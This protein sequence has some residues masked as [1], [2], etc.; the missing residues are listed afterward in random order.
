[1]ST[2]EEVA[3]AICECLDEDL[4]VRSGSVLHDNLRAALAEASA[5]VALESVELQ[6]DTSGMCTVL[7]NGRVAIRDNGDVISH[8]ATLDWFSGTADKLLSEEC[9]DGDA[10]LRM[11]GLDPEQCR[12]E[13]GRLNLAKIRAALAEAEA[14]KAEPVAWMHNQRVDC[15]HNEVKELLKR[16]GGH[17]HRPLDKTENYTIPLY[18]HPPEPVDEEVIGKHSGASDKREWW[19]RSTWLYPGDTVVVR[20]AAA[21]GEGMNLDE[22]ERAL[23]P[24]DKTLSVRQERYEPARVGVE[25]APGAVEVVGHFVLLKHAKEYAA[26]RNAAPQLIAMARRYQELRR[27]VC[28]VGT[29]KCAEFHV[30]N[31]RPT[32]IAPDAAIELDAVLD[33]MREQEQEQER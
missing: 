15:I 19:T 2:L 30:V 6:R 23:V 3:K 11:L 21:R 22:L 29:E 4:L 20:R 9:D 10:L 12:T 24:M 17:L 14:P 31:I 27:H 25:H 13:G 28:I 5:P 1:M 33:A 26:L 32:Y 16:A 8:H 7:V 18:T